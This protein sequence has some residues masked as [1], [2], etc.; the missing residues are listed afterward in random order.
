MNN[1]VIFSLPSFLP[2]RS[3]GAPWPGRASLPGS[4]S[5]G[6]PPPSVENISENISVVIIEFYRIS[7]SLSSHSLEISHQNGHLV[8]FS[9]S[10]SPAMRKSS[11]SV[12][13]ESVSLHLCSIQFLLF[14][15]TSFNDNSSVTRASSSFVF[16]LTA[17]I[18]L[19][20]AFP[21]NQVYSFRFQF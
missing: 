13:H 11:V 15:V 10:L 20:I 5:S 21:G 18:N 16:T 6:P 17:K 7:G 2:W 1:F 9:L 14:S 19:L 3:R 8:S 12:S 4:E